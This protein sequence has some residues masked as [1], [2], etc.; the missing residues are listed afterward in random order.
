[1]RWGIKAA[2]TAVF[3]R[4]NCGLSCT[5]LVQSWHGF[6]VFFVKQSFMKKPTSR[7][8]STVAPPDSRKVQPTDSKVRKLLSKTRRYIYT[9]QDLGEDRLHMGMTAAVYAALSATL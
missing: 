4:I 9:E 3:T 5:L 8:F 7:N 6:K 1:M 2:D